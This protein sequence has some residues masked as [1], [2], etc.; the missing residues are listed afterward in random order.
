MRGVVFELRRNFNDRRS[1]Y[2]RFHGIKSINRGNRGRSVTSTKYIIGETKVDNRAT[3]EFVDSRKYTR[4]P[5][6]TY[7]AQRDRDYFVSCL[8]AN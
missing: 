2:C 3:A 5:V 7:S 8:R 4:N 6:E 1:Y